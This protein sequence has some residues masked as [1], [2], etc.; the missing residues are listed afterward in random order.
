M[1]LM[2]PY[3]WVERERKQWGGGRGHYFSWDTLG[4][5]G[6]AGELS[7]IDRLHLTMG[8]CSTLKH[9]P[10]LWVPAGQPRPMV[11]LPLVPEHTKNWEPFRS[12]GKWDGI[13]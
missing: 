5:L 7:Q 13:T 8:C 10:R 1:L 3:G 9:H 2:R 12:L 11:V 4:P 6:P